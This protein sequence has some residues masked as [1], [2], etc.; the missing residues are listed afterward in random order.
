MKILNK[1]NFCFKEQQNNSLMSCEKFVKKKINK[2]KLIRTRRT[3][4][5]FSK[6]LKSK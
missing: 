1:R 3:E 4:I 6:L 5:Y 2:Q